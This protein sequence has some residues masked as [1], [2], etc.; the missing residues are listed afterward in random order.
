MIDLARR[1]QQP[2]RAEHQ[3]RRRA[4]SDTTPQNS[5]E[6]AGSAPA[7]QTRR[8]T[9]VHAHSPAQMRD[10]GDDAT[11]HVGQDDDVAA[12]EIGEAHVAAAVARPARFELDRRRAPCTTATAVSPVWR[13]VSDRTRSGTSRDV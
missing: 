4:A 7:C 13:S 3:A 8:T 12:E 10:H 9:R 5:V 1:P 11:L 2:H 6:T